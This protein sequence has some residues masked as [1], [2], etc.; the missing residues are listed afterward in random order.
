MNEWVDALAH[1]E[2]NWPLMGFSPGNYSGKC[3]SCGKTCN[4]IDKRAF[5]CLPCAIDEANAC[6]VEL[7]NVVSKL[8]NE[9]GVLRA[10]I[11]IA[12][13]PDGEAAA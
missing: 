9:N 1:R 2:P 13:S 11:Q 8:R 3:N 5:H 4:G 6:L 7:G 10:A 12:S